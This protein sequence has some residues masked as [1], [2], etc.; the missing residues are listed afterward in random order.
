MTLSRHL[1]E[2][3]DALNNPIKESAQSVITRLFELSARIR[4]SHD[5]LPVP[6]SCRQIS[7]LDSTGYGLNMQFCGMQIVLHRGL[8]KI[9]MQ[10]NNNSNN[11]TEGNGASTTTRMSV[12]PD[13]RE[14]IERSLDTMYEYAVCI[15]RLVLAY[16]E[17]FGIESFVTIIL[18]N[19]YLAS[20]TLISHSIQVPSASLGHTT[21]GIRN[22][23]NNNNSSTTTTTT[24][25]LCPDT[26]Q[27]L[28]VMSDTLESL[29]KHFP[30]ALK[31]HRTLSRI[32]ENA[33]LDGVFGAKARSTT[34]G[35]DSATAA[36]GPGTRGMS[37]FRNG[38][39]AGGSH[40]HHNK[41]NDAVFGKES[42]GMSQQH[43]PTAGLHPHHPST[44][45]D[46]SR[47]LAMGAPFLQPSFSGS[48]GSM[49]ALVHDDFL[50][51]QNG[52]LGDHSG[53][54]QGGMGADGSF[55][56]V[57]WPPVEWNS[58]ILA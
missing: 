12:D 7:D 3:T 41:N 48:W 40:G 19:M 15:S 50:L 46:N 45:L 26:V 9:L 42:S 11:T 18:D 24:T 5:M 38:A 39:G 30:V 17:I 27:L 20:S 1:S 43:Q 36:D 54:G 51:G 56:D 13:S 47:N 22:N 49:E 44:M 25:Q 55:E 10:N 52:L 32:C 31:M 6:L 35:D 23:N 14:K 58:G 34:V 16:R 53:G 57:G 2:V 33:G 29:T 8:I 21:T 28:N 4:S 37:S